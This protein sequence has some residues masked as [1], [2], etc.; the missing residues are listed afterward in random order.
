L[1]DDHFS[2]FGFGFGRRLGRRRLRLLSHRTVAEER[3]ESPQRNHQSDGDQAVLYE[4]QGG[5]G[6]TPGCI[7]Q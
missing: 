1:A 5:V 4:T 6:A 7:S 2:G 3:L